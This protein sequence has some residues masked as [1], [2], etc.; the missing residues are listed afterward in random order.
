MNELLLLVLA[1][2]LGQSSGAELIEQTVASAELPRECAAEYLPFRQ[3][4]SSAHQPRVCR[5]DLDGDRRE[6]LLVWTG[7]F[8]SGG[9]NWSVMTCRN[10]HWRQAG[11]VFGSLYRLE[12][13]PY[14]GLLVETPCGWEQATWR[15][16]ELQNGLLVCRLKLDIHYR[17]PENHVLRTRPTKIIIED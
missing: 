2:V 3:N 11:Q 6:E 10:G 7:E 4:G 14:R 8:G 16:W 17:P 13:P 9:E 12:H 15:Y 5:C 1:V